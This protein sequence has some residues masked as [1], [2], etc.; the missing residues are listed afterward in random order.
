MGPPAG[1]APTAEA[2]RAARRARTYALAVWAVP[3]ALVLTGVYWRLAIGALPLG[4]GMLSWV[5]PAAI[6]A[7]IAALLWALV[8]EPNSRGNALGDEL[9]AS[10]EIDAR[11]VARDE[12]LVAQGK[13]VQEHAELCA[14]TV[15]AE[16]L[17]ANECV[18][19]AL[20]VSHR[21]LQIAS[22]V[23]GVGTVPAVRSENL[24]KPTMPHVDRVQ[25]RARSE[26]A[27]QRELGTQLGVQHLPEL[28]ALPSP[29]VALTNPADIPPGTDHV[30]PRGLPAF[31]GST[32]A[33]TPAQP[34]GEV[35]EQRRPR[36]MRLLLV[37]LV[38][39]LVAALVWLL[40]I[41]RSS[42]VAA[43]PAPSPSTDVGVPGQPALPSG[44][45]EGVDY[46]FLGH[47]PDG[48][49]SRW[50]CDVPITVRL[51]GPAPAGA[52]DA[53]AGAVTA[54]KQASGLPLVVGSP[55][56]GPVTDPAQVPDGEIL[57]SYLTPEEIAAAHLDLTGD[58]LGRGGFQSDPA[59]G[60]ATSGLV[61]I[62][63]DSAADPAT[64]LGRLVAWHEGAHAV[65]LGHA[66][67]DSPHTEV[68][69]P[70][71]DGAASLA[72]GPGDSYALAA[73]G[74]T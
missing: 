30:D 21:A 40:L 50:G 22:G 47:G 64:A 74:C 35:P 62:R 41:N 46:S 63:A 20:E 12:E 49:A 3:I 60:R 37:L 14:E 17:E 13:Q 59:S 61:T 73:V 54:L 72:W 52:E 39:V 56:P 65:G 70:S 51:A 38:V 69:A 27:L 9:R 7:V 11:A 5:L 32:L 71:I 44:L 23:L 18:T 45:A 36:R 6:A 68:M 28:E 58:V 15:E 8:V 34:V 66:R 2:V 33:G 25:S 29:H 43:A 10:T 1:L 57:Y 67:Q 19:D 24:V 55:L 4:L 42:P 53:V 16:L 31:A 26:L 48:Q